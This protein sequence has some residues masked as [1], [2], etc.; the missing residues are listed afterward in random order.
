MTVAPSFR[1]GCIGHLNADDMRHAVATMTEVLT[2]MGV[3]NGAPAQ[4]A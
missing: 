1:V 3:A 4:A 2:D